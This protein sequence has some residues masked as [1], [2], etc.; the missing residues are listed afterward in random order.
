MENSNRS[1]DLYPEINKSRINNSEIFVLSQI[2]TRRVIEI[3]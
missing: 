1:F 3:Q 2:R